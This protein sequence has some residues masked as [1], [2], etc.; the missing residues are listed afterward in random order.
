M[1]NAYELTSNEILRVVGEAAENI[2]AFPSN[3]PIKGAR[4]TDGEIVIVGP[5]DESRIKTEQ[6]IVGA[7]RASVL[8]SLVENGASDEDLKK[9]INKML[10]QRTAGEGFD[11][12]LR[13][14][15][16][17]ANLS[18]SSNATFN[19]VRNNED[20]IDFTALRNDIKGVP[21][22]E[23]I[24]AYKLGSGKALQEELMS[25]NYQADSFDGSLH[26]ISNERQF[27][28]GHNLADLTD[29][30]NSFA[31]KDELEKKAKF[32]DEYF[33]NLSKSGIYKDQKEITI[34]DVG[35]ENGELTT[36]IAG[37]ALKHFPE[38][39][40]NIIAVERTD[41]FLQSCTEKFEEKLKTNDRLNYKPVVNHYGDSEKPAKLEGVEKVDLFL[42]T[43]VRNFNAVHLV[44]ESAGYA[45]ENAVILMKH[46]NNNDMGARMGAEL[47]PDIVRNTAGK[48]EMIEQDLTKA[49]I[50]NFSTAEF[51]AS[52][53]FGMKGFSDED[54]QALQNIKQGDFLNTVFH[55]DADKL[56]KL[57]LVE[58]LVGAP[59]AAFTP[60]HRNMVIDSFNGQIRQG[61]ATLS[62]GCQLISAKNKE[63]Q[64]EQINAFNDSIKAINPV[65]QNVEKGDD[66]WVK[67]L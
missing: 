39:K 37:A 63:L 41:N 57:R 52:F 30:F 24:L 32:H 8:K 44:N 43:D 59:I 2:P 36:R 35:T 48:A 5:H 49:G 65:I 58:F 61:F 31:A 11:V 25:K 54:K 26:S 62:S 50:T 29:N 16:I 27:V 20:A 7:L 23:D 21:S 53:G 19:K 10:N 6:V 45:N 18:L 42:V 67:N 28:K 64:P 17:T 38:H 55:D 40:I 9:A 66:S 13:M 14:K 51:K 12:D 34:M 3:L 56:K 33:S 60:E 46:N 1:P 22:T 15:S 47:G 4:N